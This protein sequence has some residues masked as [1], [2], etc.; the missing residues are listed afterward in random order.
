MSSIVKKGISFTPKVKKTS[1]KSAI[2]RASTTPNTPEA[3][4]KTPTSQVTVSTE[5]KK[6]HH[7]H[8]HNHNNEA[9]R[10]RPLETPPNSQALEL[11]RKE[12]SEGGSGLSKKSGNVTIAVAAERNDSLAISKYPDSAIVD[13]S[14]EENEEGDLSIQQNKNKIRQFSHSQR[15]L[16]GINQVGYRSRSSSV[17][18]KPQDEAH[19]ASTQGPAR[20][21]IPQQK[22]AKRR[23]SSVSRSS[24]RRSVSYPIPIVNT[25]APTLKP[26]MLDPK[27]PLR[28]AA[29]NSA[30]ADFATTDSAISALDLHKSS[31]KGVPRAAPV[32]LIMNDPDPKP[33]SVRE[34]KSISEKA[35]GK[36]KEEE[37][38][39]EDESSIL[40]KRRRTEDVVSKEFVLGIDPK[41][42][43]VRKFRRKDALK[44]EVKSENG[45]SRVADVMLDDIA[46]I[47]PDNLVTTVTSV[48]QIPVNIKEEDSSLYAE[49]DYAYEGMTM[50]DLCKPTL[51][52]GQVSSNHALVVEAEKQMKQEKTQRRLDRAR[53]RREK[54]SLEE[55]RLLNEG[56][57]SEDTKSDDDKT[58]KNKKV[59][60]FSLDDDDQSQTSTAIQLTL[61]DGKIG[62]KEESAIVVKQRVDTSNRI[63]EQA[64]PYSNP[65]TSATY[66]KQ[67]HTDKWT[68]AELQEFYKALSMFGTDFSLISQLFPHRTRK[69]IKSKFALEEKKYPEVV[70]LALKRKLPVD[71]E[72]YRK[73]VKNDIKTIEQYNENLRK[74]RFEHEESMNA[75][76]MEREK[77]YREDAE[78]SRRREIE[79]R[80]GTKPMTRAEKVKELRKNE[81][82]VGSIDDVKRNQRM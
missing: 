56:K 66:G 34:K 30:A 10:I 43:K 52:I 78:A 12:A 13:S 39:R 67:L 75:I 49:L 62:Y 22:T 11:G 55:A 54:I 18:Q 60:L 51:K 79:I 47:E 69:Q 46:P 73:N 42:N 61:L 71:F 77:A 15:R 20:I 26:S 63:V 72:E 59:D 65:V 50:A 58:N 80:T 37:K 16:S 33:E 40:S 27:I 4:Q 53:A 9:D 38:E 24:K 31:P 68:S 48:S 8:H 14:D 23:R 1:K 32:S 3:T 7:H 5:K 19:T 29:A 45:F 74:V 17:S 44:K 2:S 57:T 64:N 70:E 35:K 21:I 36:E 81:I 76:A 41:T 25:I 82:V 6:K 28:P